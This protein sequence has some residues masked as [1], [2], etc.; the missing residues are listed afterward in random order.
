MT[1]YVRDL[2][3]LVSAAA[4]AV[5]P[6]PYAV[7][8]Q[9]KVLEAMASGTPVVASAAAAGGLCATH[10]RDLLVADT[11]EEFADATLRLLDDQETWRSV[12]EHGANYV[13]A[14]HNWETITQRLTAVYERALA[15]RSRQRVASELAGLAAG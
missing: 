15:S 5:S 14:Q 7:G 12:A 6:L 13:A 2:N 3:A 4:V 11:A 1:G 10:G 8:I 9:N